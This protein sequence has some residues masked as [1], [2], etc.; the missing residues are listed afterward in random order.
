MVVLIPRKQPAVSLDRRLGGPCSHSGEHRISAT[1]RQ[2]CGVITIQDWDCNLHSS[3]PII[4]SYSVNFRFTA[5]YPV[6]CN[7]S[8]RLS[9]ERPFRLRFV[10]YKSANPW[11]WC[12]INLRWTRKKKYLS[13][14]Q[15]VFLTD[16][17]TII[18]G[19]SKRAL[20]LWRRIEIYTE[21]IHN[22]LNYQN[23]AKHIEFYLG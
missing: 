21:D 11:S 8:L 3:Q 18:Q 7:D 10:W 22:V 5:Y 19:I 4:Q 15:F 6:R 16:F 9:V 17:R 2:T 14:F 13:C 20:Q 23:V 12:F 1:R